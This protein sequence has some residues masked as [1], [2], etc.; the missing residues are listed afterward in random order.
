MGK[1]NL[2]NSIKV[3]KP[4]ASVFDMTHDHKLSLNMGNLV[5]ICCME[6]M[7]GDKWTLSNETLLRF[8]PLIAPVMHRLNM[9]VHYYFV[10]SRILWKGWSD[11]ITNTKVGTPTPALPVPPYLDISNIYAALPL[12]N[13]MGVPP[14]P[15]GADLSSLRVSALPFAAYQKIY[16]EYYRDQ[17]LVSKLFDSSFPTL[18]D[19]SNAAKID[20]LV[21]LRKRAWMHDYFTAALPFAQKGD[22]VKIP[23]GGFEDVPVRVNQANT[24]GGAGS[25]ANTLTPNP[26]L[27]SGDT[28]SYGADAGEDLY[29]ETSQIDQGEST[30]NDLRLAETLQKWY[31]KAARGGSRLVEFIRVMFGVK[32][33]DARLQRP[34]F[35]CG[36]SSPVQISEVLNTTGTVDLP[37]GN[38]SGHGV[39]GMSGNYGSFFCEEHGFIVGI[40]SVLPVT[41]YQQ[42]LHPMWTRLTDP[43]EYPWPTFAN[44]GEQEIKNRE[45]YAW[46]TED[47]EV[48]GY[49]PRYAEW[50]YMPSRV[51]GRF[52]DNLAYW[53]FGRI[54]NDTPVLNQT[55]IE[56]TPRTDPF[57][58]IEED[59]E[60]LY[61][62]T[63]IK[64]SVYRKLPKFG[65]PTL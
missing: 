53:H 32:S 54:F 38:M 50:K 3:D 46:M 34:E 39:S 51:S 56:C 26:I 19:G 24:P 62:H 60:K 41:A 61:A 33:S 59:D 58:V 28:P 31:E 2:F 5:P 44:I 15:A 20:M 4:K 6:A 21:T 40:L 22:D 42:G 63:L 45:L 27:I 48:F 43:T 13:Y 47:P 35:I 11:F 52:Q 1:L 14:V 8:A 18:V 37:Q 65:T 12:V 36:V 57:A 7:P 64:A 17:N 25:I 49:I 23:I 55:F 9:F 29:A 16:D 10:P 30:I